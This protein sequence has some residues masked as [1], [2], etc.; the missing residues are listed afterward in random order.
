MP[1]A[2]LITKREAADILG[3]TPSSVQRMIPKHLSPKDTVRC[4]DKVV[5]HLFSR[6]DVERLAKR[7]AA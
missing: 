1:R 2:T 7:R 6:A 4:G 3:V 5:A